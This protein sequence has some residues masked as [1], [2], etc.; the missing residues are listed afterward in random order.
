MNHTGRI[1]GVTMKRLLLLSIV[2]FAVLQPACSKPVPGIS[3]FKA[4][5][6]QPIR[7]EFECPEQVK[8]Q[9]ASVD[10]S[11]LSE[12]SKALALQSFKENKDKSLQCYV[13]FGPDSIDVNGMQSIP[14]ESVKRFWE[15]YNYTSL[16]FER[17][18][19]FLYE[20]SVAG[21]GEK[22]L[23]LEIKKGWS[24]PSREDGDFYNSYFQS[25]M[26][27]SSS[28]ASK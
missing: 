2:G 15:V 17:F 7:F 1:H 13:G 14:R 6:T 10:L 21:L 18:W 8:L 11:M 23:K 12:R 22:I 20:P 9:A 25:W 28:S 19:Y 26:N 27:L 24:G 5:L 4:D 16:G 3:D